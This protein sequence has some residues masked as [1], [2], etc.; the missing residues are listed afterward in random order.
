METKPTLQNY[1]GSPAP[2]CRVAIAVTN[3]G[4]T[5]HVGVQIAECRAVHPKS[6]SLML[7]PLKWLNFMQVT[8]TLPTP[9]QWSSA[10]QDAC[11]C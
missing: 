4:E 1:L 5:K 10:L 6:W 11:V 2:Q 7:F 8:V 3:G 9:V